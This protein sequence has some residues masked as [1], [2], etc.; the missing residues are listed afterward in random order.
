MG[1]H[2]IELPLNPEY[3][4]RYARGFRNSFTELISGAVSSVVHREKSR[5]A[6]DLRAQLTNH[7]E[8]EALLTFWEA[9][10][11]GANGFRIRDWTDFTTASDRRSAAAATDRTIGTGDG[12]TTVF[13]LRTSYTSGGVTKT[14]PITKPVTGTT[15]VAFD[16]VEQLSGWTVNT[17]T[18]IVTFTSAPGAGVVVTAGCEFHVP[19]RF[20][21]EA[22]AKLSAAVTAFDVVAMEQVM[23]VEDLD[24][25]PLD[26][27]RHFGGGRAFGAISANLSIAVLDGAAL[28][29]NP[30]VAGLSVTLPAVNTLPAVGPDFFTLLNESFVYSL[31]VK[32]SGGA[33]IVT[34][35]PRAAARL[36]VFAID[37]LG[38]TAWRA[39]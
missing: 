23:V 32:D 35:G 3:Q 10:T 38:T 9:R 24:P 27:E 36:G 16:G 7:A 28:T 37:A 22:D 6:F 34:L 30:S 18:G 4:S 33:T 21:P 13:Q 29:F 17:T 14:R 2:E 15:R 26:D 31:A 39:T 1:F 11:G 25:S 5:R 20:T 12:V 8:A 19:V